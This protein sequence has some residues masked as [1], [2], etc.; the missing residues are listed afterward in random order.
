M[1]YA[2]N[3]SD[4]VQRHYVASAETF[5]AGVAKDIADGSYID[6]AQFEYAMILVNVTVETGTV[7]SLTITAKGCDAQTTP[8]KTVIDGTNVKPNPYIITG[9][10]AAESYASEFRLHG[11]DTLM[12]VEILVTGGTSVVADVTV[13]LFRNQYTRDLPAMEL[14]DAEIGVA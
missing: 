4:F 11:A 13:L 7:T 5:A 14:L 12:D 1:T 8:T 2:S 6:V 9:P 10:N 3:P